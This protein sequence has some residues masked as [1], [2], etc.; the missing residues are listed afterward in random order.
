MYECKDSNDFDFYFDSRELAPQYPLN[1]MIVRNTYTE[2]DRN[3]MLF[4]SADK[5]GI[6]KIVFFNAIPNINKYNEVLKYDY[7]A[8]GGAT[9][10]SREINLNT[11][12]ITGE[13][14]ITGIPSIINLANKVLYRYMFGVNL[15]FINEPPIF[16]PLLPGEKDLVFLIINFDN[17]ITFSTD[18]NPNHLVRFTNENKLFSFWNDGEFRSVQ[19]STPIDLLYTKYIDIV[20]SDLQQYSQVKSR[21][22]SVKTKTLLYRFYIQ[23]SYIDISAFR[24]ENPWKVYSLLPE[25]DFPSYTTAEEKNT[26]TINTLGDDFYRDYQRVPV[27][28]S[29]YIVDEP[30]N[31]S[32]FS[33]RSDVAVDNFNI[34]LLDDQG[35]PLYIPSNPNRTDKFSG[36]DLDIVFSLKKIN[37]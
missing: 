34:Q 5:I 12:N 24:T 1:D 18:G 26:K 14:V 3:E 13:R 35:R 9:W 17:R 31:I 27:Y 37:K 20:S 16:S 29:C 32:Y 28:P 33:F 19:V 7:T 6:K 15:G 36:I 22:N 8:D 30:Q 11:G 10:V 4:T 21:S 2:G 23:P 25:A